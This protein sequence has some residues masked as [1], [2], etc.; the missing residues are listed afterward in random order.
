MDFIFLNKKSQET[1]E[2]MPHSYGQ[3]A[4]THSPLG[5]V[6]YEIVIENNN[7]SL[8]KTILKPHKEFLHRNNCFLWEMGI[9]TQPQGNI[10]EYP[11]PGFSSAD[12]LLY[13]TNL[14]KIIHAQ[15]VLCSKPSDW[16]GL[17][18]ELQFHCCVPASYRGKS[19][20]K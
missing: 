15:P 18:R 19:L 13:K 3:L 14:D 7:N 2:L 11:L 10:K 8:K 17:S 6:H 16:S 9:Q 4:K 20:E 12:S 5:N 1:Q